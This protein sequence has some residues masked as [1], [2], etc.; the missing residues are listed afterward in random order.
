MRG[1]TPGPVGNCL[2]AGR[3]MP[4]LALAP[5]LSIGGQPGHDA[6]EIVRFDTHLLRDLGDRDPGRRTHKL[7]RLVGPR[8]TPAAAPRPAGTSTRCRAPS[9]LR[10]GAAC[11]PGTTRSTPAAGQRAARRLQPGNLFLELAQA[12]IDLLHGCVDEASQI[13]SPSVVFGRQDTTSECRF[14]CRAPTVP[15]VEPV[16]C[17]LRA[18]MWRRR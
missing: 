5:D 14:I 11:S 17:W 18:R 4:A 13:E 6:V 9:G 15:S 12:I 8:A 3:R 1:G 10:P 7:E 16:N 2:S